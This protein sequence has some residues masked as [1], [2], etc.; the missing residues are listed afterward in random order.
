[1]YTFIGDDDGV[2]LL[3][4][5]TLGGKGLGARDCEVEVAAVPVDL[6]ES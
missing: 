5:S 3:T 4:V 2:D 1:M 6:I